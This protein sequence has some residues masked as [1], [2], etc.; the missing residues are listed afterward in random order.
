MKSTL[1]L[2]LSCLQLFGAAVQWDAD[3][4]VHPRL[5]TG[6]AG[7][8]LDADFRGLS[9]SSNAYFRS[10]IITND[11]TVGGTNITGEL[12]SKAPIVGGLVPLANLP[13]AD[14]GETSSTELVRADDSR[15]TGGGPDLIAI[16]ALTGTGGLHRTGD[17]TWALRTLTGDSEITVANGTGVS[18][19]PTLS[20]GAIA[21]TKI[22]FSDPDSNWTATEVNTALAEMDDVINGGL[23]NAATGKIDWSQIV[24]VPAGIA[25]GDDAE[26]EAGSGD[27][28]FI[29]GGTIT[30]PD[31]DSNTNVVWQVNGTNVTA[32]V[33]NI[34][35]GQVVDGTLT[36][37]DLGADS[38]SASELNA[39][40]VAA[41]LE[42][43]MVLQNIG[44]AV[45]DNQV[46]NNI[47]VDLSTL[48]STVTVVDSTD[49]SSSVLIADSATGSLAVK[50]D[51]GLSYNATTGVLTA[52]G[53]A[54]PITGNVTGDVTGN[55]GTVTVIDGS[56]AS[57]FVL[58][59]DSAT[60]SLP[61]KTDGAL[62]YNAS[63]GTLTATTF[64]GAGGGLTLVAS[65]FNGN[66][67]T[68]DDTLQEVAQKLD[69]LV[70]GAGDQ[71]PW[72]SDIDAATFSL[73]NLAGIKGIGTGVTTFANTNNI[74]STN[75]T[76]DHGQGSG[77][78]EIGQNLNVH[79]NFT[80]LGTAAITGV[81]TQTGNIEL[82][83]AT[84]NTLSAT[85]GNLLIEN[86][87]VARQGHTL[88]GEVSATFES[89]GSTA[90]TLADSVAV[91]S[92]NLTTPT[93]TTHVDIGATG[94]RIS[95]DG[96]G[97]ITFLGR[98]AGA[99][100]DLTLNLDDTADTIMVSSS[101][102]MNNISFFAIDL[103]VPTEAYDATGWNA[104]NSVPTKDA[105]RDKI[106]SMSITGA[107]TDVDYLVGTANGSLSAEIVVGTTPG[108]ELGGTWG[109]PTLDDSVT[110]ATWTMTGTL[111]LTV[112]NGATTAGAIGF[113]EDGDNG[114]NTV[115][116]I[117]PASTADVTVTLPATAG[118]IL[119]SGH[120]FTGDA[121]ATL[122]SDGST[123]VTVTP[124]TGIYRTIW[125]DA[126]AMI[127]RTTAG[128]LAGTEELASNDIMM[129]YFAFDDTT[130]EAVQFK[131]AMPDEWDR[132]TVKVKLFWYSASATTTHTAV[133]GVKARAVSNDDAL[134]GTWGTEVEV[135]DDVIAAGDL[136]VTAATG[137]IT[138]GGTPALGDLIMF[139]V[140]QDAAEADHSGDVKL[141][142]VM[143]QYLE[144]TTEPTVW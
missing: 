19:N 38:V 93:V 139:E 31:F 47:T 91:T 108:G 113:K 73:T 127:S 44:G 130:A 98:S 84:A 125:V 64:A 10:L 50:T 21:G 104:D 111:G 96:D 42:A 119:V 49:A 12:A 26:G 18:G 144:S 67:A 103:T 129:D 6:V 135:S 143:I 69:D 24:N 13:V 65:G 110:V 102:G 77:S 78:F 131:L 99:D 134:D 2:L 36:A 37:A 29:D 14:S 136:H 106:E 124:Q 109:S 5:E 141:T 120:T 51:A 116:L 39:S 9:V 40:G 138:V 55:A 132:G 89:D 34:V 92:W 82:N 28:V 60:G 41:E 33:T 61:V 118:T 90:V 105:V 35:S 63:N 75:Y 54:G 16:E 128:A 117:G 23:P 123:A 80:A 95:D 57:S 25:D 45:I 121:T 112:N 30:H 52:T 11:L 68:T 62:L 32:Y 22:N 122:D 48:A 4:K 85:G 74:V 107:P 15:L 56:D 72:A 79:S 101:T 7:W 3:H 86:N 137:A 8:Y 43:A 59:A 83:H 94:V 133:W 97:A 76:A 88:G 58:I 46:P 1:L 70:L 142:G 140:D 71:T 81:L 27:D 66:L 115:T 126:G 17:G 53:F 87:V 114:A 100:E 20:I